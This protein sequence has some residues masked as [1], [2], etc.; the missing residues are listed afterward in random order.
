MD[1]I[2]QPHLPEESGTPDGP[3]CAGCER[4]LY[5]L[6]GR[7]PICSECREAYIRYP[8]PKWI[9]IF[10][11]AILVLMAVGLTRLPGNLS[12]A[13]HQK[14]GERAMAEHRYSTAQKELQLALKAQPDYLEANLRL[15]VAAYYNEDFDL[16]ART[17]QK[18]E[19]HKIDNQELYEAASDVAAKINRHYP[20]D[21]LQAFVLAQPEPPYEI[22]EASWARYLE[23][24]PSE[25]FIALLRAAAAVDR[26]QYYLA[27]D[28]M[29]NTLALDPEY[30]RG[31]QQ[32]VTIK[33]EL[34][35]F[36]SAHY[37]ADRLLALNRE[38]PASFGTKARILLKQHKDG[39]AGKVLQEGLRID[40]KDGYC[41]ATL[42]L[43]YHYQGDEGHRDALLQKAAKD[44]TISGQFE[45]VNKVISGQESFRN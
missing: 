45:Y 30:T 23:N 35:Q 41:L 38:M 12:A 1:T 18:L 11:A 22:P 37:Y 15:M 4:P 24:H 44:T 7:T 19:G 29:R 21:S 16:A 17:G 42:A 27:Q 32:M 3:L 26:K 10:G 36:D 9:R 43:L 2:E 20:S 34:N 40:P 14:R 13:I 28:L 33:R 5:E 25:D 8:I 39:E 6:T 31:L